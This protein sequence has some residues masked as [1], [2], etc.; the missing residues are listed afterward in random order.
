MSSNIA[1]GVPGPHRTLVQDGSYFPPGLATG[2]QNSTH[3]SEVFWECTR[4]CFL[5]QVTDEGP[6]PSPLHHCHLYLNHSHF[7]NSKAGSGVR[8]PSF[9]L[10]LSPADVEPGANCLSSHAPMCEAKPADRDPWQGAAR[11]GS[12]AVFLCPGHNSP[13]PSP[14]QQTI[15]EQC[16]PTEI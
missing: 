13:H 14:S 5:Q 12:R 11:L 16:W 2:T 10:A 4:T 8:L 3:S 7:W 6:E 15:L 1:P 9:N